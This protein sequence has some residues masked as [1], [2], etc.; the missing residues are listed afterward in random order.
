[1]KKR[2]E[3]SLLEQMKISNLE[4]TN[5]L[6]LVGFSDK[7]RENLISFQSIIHNEVPNVVNDF[8]KHETSIVEVAML[9]GDSDTLSRLHNTMRG[10]IIDLFAGYYDLEYVNNRLRIGQIHKRIGVEPKLY[11][12]AMKNLL[13]ILVEHINQSSFSADH[14]RNIIESLEKLLCFD[15]TL[16][17]DAYISSLSA[18]IDQSRDKIEAYAHSLEKK[19]AERTRQLEELARHDPLTGLFN[20]RVFYEY[21]R[22]DLLSAERKKQTLTL[23]YFDVDNFKGLND[24][25]GHQKGDDVLRSVAEILTETCREIDIQCRYGGDEFCVILPDCNA[26]QAEVVASRILRAF[27]KQNRGMSLS[28]G[29]AEAGPGNYSDSAELVKRADTMMY[30]AK[31]TAGS[32]YCTYK[33]EESFN[34]LESTAEILPSEL[35]A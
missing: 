18:E 12:A 34:R 4:M 25:L 28:I 10:Y 11:L 19:V 2:T 3:L 27:E 1:M 24:R 31:Q 6:Q 26:S 21:L 35:L 9:I 33:I 22:R 17:F 14:K 7:D 8:Y 30:A 15:T 29:I 16:V 23:L 20:Q 5:R 32:K 13:E